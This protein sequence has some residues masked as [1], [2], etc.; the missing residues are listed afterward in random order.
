MLYTLYTRCVCVFECKKCLQ[1]DL[2]HLGGDFVQ[3]GKENVF[4]VWEIKGLW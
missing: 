1:N 4:G 3:S 2:Y